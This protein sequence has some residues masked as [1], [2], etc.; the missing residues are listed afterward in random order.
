[1]M[2]AK[3]S[4]KRRCCMPKPKRCSKATL[5]LAALAL[6]PSALALRLH[7]L[8]RD[9]AAVMTP[10][11]RAVREVSA[12][13]ARFEQASALVTS[14]E[15]AVAE[16]L[17]EGLASAWA[18]VEPSLRA[19]IDHDPSLEHAYRDAVRIVSQSRATLGESQRTCMCLVARC[20]SIWLRNSTTP[21]A[22]HTRPWPRRRQRRPPF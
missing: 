16:L 13:R 17:L 8:P 6:A 20:P 1:M 10:S 3:T 12:L 15:A 14:G 18:S 5:V 2:L 19:A 9:S 22:T 7:D 21:S 11:L 4:S